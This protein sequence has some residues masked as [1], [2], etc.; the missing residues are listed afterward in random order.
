MACESPRILWPAQDYQLSSGEGETVFDAVVDWSGSAGSLQNWA[1]GLALREVGGARRVALEVESV[2]LLIAETGDPLVAAAM[3]P[4]DGSSG[5]GSASGQTVRSSQSVHHGCRI[6][7]DPRRARRAVSFGGR[8]PT[9]ARSSGHRL[10]SVTPY[11]TLWDCLQEAIDRHAPG[12]GSPLPAI[13]TGYCN[14]SPLTK[15]NTPLVFR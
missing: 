14:A 10:R 6:R 3:A 7:P 4:V 8:L 5:L 15:R 1:N 12:S 11:I 9:I 13:R 2:Q